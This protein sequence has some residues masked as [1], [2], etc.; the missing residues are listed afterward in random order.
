M[1]K[2]S[3]WEVLLDGNPQ[4][5]R[6]LS[7]YGH[8]IDFFRIWGGVD[9]WLDCPNDDFR[10]NSSLFEPEDVSGVWQISYEL[11]SL[12]N[13]ASELYRRSARKLSVY[14]VLLDERETDR[15]QRR[16]IPG[17]LGRPGISQAAWDIELKK[18]FA[19][20]QK[21]GLMMLAA[22]HEDVYLFLK[23]L[24]LDDSW[25]GYY[26]IL[27]T[28]ETWERRKGIRAFRSKRKEKKFT[29]SANNFSLNGFD[30]RHGFQEMMQEPAQKSMTVGEGHQF[31]TGL[32]KDYLQQ[33]YP[34]YLK[35]K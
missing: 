19:T 35:F 8:G 2:Q 4:E 21:L 27:D 12:Y 31:I 9:H 13:G 10:F 30:A 7:D 3:D 28:L 22:E 16:H 34:Q 5:I 18:A 25:V 20:S 6:Q 14:K 32:I 26:K 17:M 23:F 15:Q 24:D 1:R 29:C 11:V 33:A